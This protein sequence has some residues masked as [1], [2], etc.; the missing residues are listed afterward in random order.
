MQAYLKKHGPGPSYH[1]V[2]VEWMIRGLELEIQ[3]TI[4]KRSSR[5]WL[6]DET[7]SKDWS[8]NWGLWNRDVVEAFIQLR[9][10]PDDFLAPY[11]EI[12][13]SPKNQPFAL[14]VTEPRKKFSPPKELNFNHETFIEGKS[15]K[16][17]MKLTLPGEI[18]GSEIY[19]SFFA[20]LDDEPREYYALEVNPEAVPDFHRPELFLPLKMHE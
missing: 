8:K 12:Q 11:L 18:C 1:S 15:W 6:F 13:V 10:S 2:K 19:G 5:P 7:F 4:N 3:F 16:T 9:S 17:S 20:C 14:I